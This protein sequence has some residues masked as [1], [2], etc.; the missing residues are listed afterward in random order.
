M[1]PIKTDQSGAKAFER[2]FLVNNEADALSASAVI[3]HM[4]F[5]RGKCDKDEPLFLDPSTQKEV[6]ISKSR[7][8]LTEKV[9]LSGL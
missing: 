6:A 4:L 3:D 7:R 5:L 9:A 2:T 1:K 8:I